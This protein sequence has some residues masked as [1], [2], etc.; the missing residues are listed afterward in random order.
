MYLVPVEARLDLTAS[1]SLGTCSG[2]RFLLSNSTNRFPMDG[3]PIF[4]RNL[5]ICS[6]SNWIVCGLLQ[7]SVPAEG[8]KQNNG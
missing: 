6:F 4:D 2:G 3:A 1:M 5:S 8:N 7:I